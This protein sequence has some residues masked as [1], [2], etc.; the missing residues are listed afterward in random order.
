MQHCYWLR[1]ILSMSL[2][3]RGV[4]KAKPACSQW[5]PV[6]EKKRLLAHIEMQAIPQKQKES[7]Y[8]V[9]GQA[10][11]LIARAPVECFSVEELTLLWDSKWPGPSPAVTAGQGML[12]LW[13]LKPVMYLSLSFQPHNLQGLSQTLFIS[14]TLWAPKP[15][16][17]GIV[18]ASLCSGCV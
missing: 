16:P 1:G 10:L 18:I 4:K 3:G 6:A 17:K 2:P 11:E 13:Q 12:W 9:G 15:S 5:C 14:E 7:F 8:W